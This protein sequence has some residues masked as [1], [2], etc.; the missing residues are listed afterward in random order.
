MNTILGGQ[1]SSRLNK[2][3]REQRGYTYGVHTNFDM[4]RGIGPF[5]VRMAVQSA[6][7][8]PA[9]TDTMG[10]LRRIRRHPVEAES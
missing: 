1:F 5:A 2:L 9:I 8:V 3:L 7:T 10:E 4:R 6:V